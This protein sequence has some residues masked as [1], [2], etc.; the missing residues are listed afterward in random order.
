MIWLATDRRGSLASRIMRRLKLRQRLFRRLRLIPARETI[1]PPDGFWHGASVPETAVEDL[2]QDWLRAQL[3]DGWQII[4]DKEYTILRRSVVHRIP[5]FRRVTWNWLH[6]CRVVLLGPSGFHYWIDPFDCSSLAWPESR[7]WLPREIPDRN[8]Q[9]PSVPHHSGSFPAPATL[10]Q[11]KIES[12]DPAMIEAIRAFADTNL[13]RNSTW[14]LVPRVARISI[15]DLYERWIDTHS[16][17]ERFTALDLARLV[18][19]Y[20]GTVKGDYI[21]GVLWKERHEWYEGVV[22]PAIK[23]FLLFIGGGA[24]IASLIFSIL[25]F[26][27]ESPMP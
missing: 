10:M 4:Y 7:W 24:A 11:R 16:V 21:V 20:G 2:L 3:A 9:L 27:N 5:L 25:R 1:E 13:V 18:C 6:I 12:Q 17:P 23:W 8:L 26:L 14:V 19:V 15:H 22:G